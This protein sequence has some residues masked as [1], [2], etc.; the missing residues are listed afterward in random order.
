MKGIYIFDAFVNVEPLQRS[1]DDLS[2]YVV[3]SALVFI[4]NKYYPLVVSCIKLV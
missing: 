1:E 2:L 4:C 3:L